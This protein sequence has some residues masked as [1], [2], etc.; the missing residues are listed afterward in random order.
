MGRNP[1][2]GAAKPKPRPAEPTIGIPGIPGMPDISSTA[3]W[4]AAVQLEANDAVAGVV[5]GAA[6]A[7]LCG[8]DK[9][10]TKVPRPMPA[11]TVPAPP[12]PAGVMAATFP[13]GIAGMTLGAISSEPSMPSPPRLAACMT[14]I[15][16]PTWVMP[17]KEYGVITPL[18]RF[19]A[20]FVMSPGCKPNGKDGAAGAAAGAASACNVVGV[21]VTICDSALCTPV[22]ADEP[23]DWATAALCATS[24]L[25]LVFCC[26]AVNGV[27]LVAAAEAPA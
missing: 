26:G 19:V 24:P 15:S 7:Q 20:A 12:K 13:P 9:A 21:V 16:A 1:Y 4:G 25:G 6:D 23:V 2:R 8:T 11:V 5:A 27:T 22:P 14:A 10:P 18:T 17:A 3:A